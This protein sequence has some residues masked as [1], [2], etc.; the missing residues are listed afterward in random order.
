MGVREIR[1]LIVSNKKKNKQTPPTPDQQARALD[2]LRVD[3]SPPYFGNKTPPACILSLEKDELNKTTLETVVVDTFEE[4]QARHKEGYWGILISCHHSYNDLDIPR[5]EGEFGQVLLDAD[6]FDLL[7]GITKA[8]ILYSEFHSVS[9]EAERTRRENQIPIIE[10]HTS[11][12]MLTKKDRVISDLVTKKKD[13]IKKHN[14]MIGPPKKLT[15]EEISRL[16]NE[17]E[18]YDWRC[19]HSNLIRTNKKA[20]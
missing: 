3:L 10:W 1:G 13:R 5:W 4:Y 11:A 12:F 7:N 6:K 2:F 16:V 9:E 17:V 14:D 19:P 8:A 15:D 20:R 18:E